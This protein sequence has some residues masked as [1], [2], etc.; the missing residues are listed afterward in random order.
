[1]VS[2]VV[3]HSS[4]YVIGSAGKLPWHLPGDMR[5]FRE[6]TTGH[7]VVMGRKTFESLPDAYRPL[8]DRRNLVLSANPN[9]RAE[10]V[11]IYPTLEAVLQAAGEECFVIGGATIYR[12]A[13]PLAQRVYATHVEGTHEG[14]VFFPP[15]EEHE[16]HCVQ[17]SDRILENGHAYT[18]RVYDRA[19]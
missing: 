5:N 14:D 10:G 16:W 13:L 18:M 19:S 4:N 17:R 9:Y 2:L 1:M 6:L 8:P 7:T 15:L 3:A 11:E 12:Q